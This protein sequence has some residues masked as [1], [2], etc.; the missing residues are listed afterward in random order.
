MYEPCSVSVTGG[1]TTDKTEGNRNE[2]EAYDIRTRNVTV[3]RGNDKGAGR[4]F[5]CRMAPSAHHLSAPVHYVPLSLRSLRGADND[6][7]S[8]RIRTRT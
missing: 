3:R 2:R 5:V 6:N 1:Q 4:K 7:M 8:G